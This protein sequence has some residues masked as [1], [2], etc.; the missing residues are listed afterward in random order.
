VESVSELTLGMKLDELA[1]MREENELLG[2]A[3][4]RQKTEAWLE[5][6]GYT[7]AVWEPAERDQ[8]LLRARRVLNSNHIF[9]LMAEPHDPDEE[10]EPGPRKVVPQ[11]GNLGLLAPQFCTRL[12]ISNRAFL[13]CQLFLPGLLKLEQDFKAHQLMKRVGVPGVKHSTVVTAITKPDLET[14]EVLGDAYL[15]VVMSQWVLSQDP[16]ITREGLLTDYRSNLVRGGGGLAWLNMS[17]IR[18]TVFAVTQVSNRRLLRIAMGKKLE[19]CL[20]LRKIIYNEPFN[21]WGPSL[22]AP[23]PDATPPEAP[24]NMVHF[25]VV[26]DIVECKGPTAPH[27]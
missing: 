19:G 25:K 1:A 4:K 23:P 21:T 11:L 27:A 3:Q 6:R 16:P 5:P 7:R 26:A 15:K 22:V 17:P 2:G 13:A 18:L 12:P 10:E 14:L 9:R 20:H 24:P 8:P